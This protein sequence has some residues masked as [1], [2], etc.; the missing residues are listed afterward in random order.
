[1]TVVFVHGNPETS[2]IWKPL[3]DELTA[4]GTEDIV[5]VS[6]PG[7]GSPVPAGFGATRIEYAA[8]LAHELENIGELVHLIGHDWGGPHVSA[9]AINRP[10]LLRSWCIDTAGLL[11]PDYVWHDMAQ[12]WQTPGAGEDMLAAWCAA[13]AADRAGLFQAN[14]MSADDA[15]RSG[16]AINETMA[17]CIVKLY[18]SGSQPAMATLGREAER[19]RERPGLV[20]V[21]SDDTYVGTP[22]MA[23]AVAQQAGA[24][25]APLNGV[26]H[27]WMLQDPTTA[28]GLLQ[29]WF[30]ENDKGP[31]PR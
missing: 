25:V 6:P 12:V 18:R 22:D 5:C 21:A 7:F 20:I 2:L 31:A 23:R 3:V 13:P 30:A 15:L 29:W 9:V 24:H 26:G 27:W 19:M 14:G 11:H 17:D 10:D 16:E 8:W 4:R 1:M 28:A